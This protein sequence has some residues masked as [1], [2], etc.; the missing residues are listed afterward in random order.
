[1]KSDQCAKISC[2]Q[3]KF[4]YSERKMVDVLDKR[5]RNGKDNEDLFYEKMTIQKDG[6]RSWS[7]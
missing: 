7:F 3:R 2:I 1:M 5:S 4:K 6:S